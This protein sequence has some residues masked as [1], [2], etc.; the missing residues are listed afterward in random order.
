MRI[1]ILKRTL[2]AAVAS[3]VWMAG[4]SLPARAQDHQERKHEQKEMKKRE[5]QERKRQHAVAGNHGNHYGRISDERYRAHF[6]HKHQFRMVRFRRVEGYNRFAYS[7][8]TFGFVQPWP[9]GWFRND[10]VYVEYVDGGYY[11]CNPRQPGIRITLTI[12]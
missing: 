1:S 5:K 10:D 6:G 9:A 7:G 2:L 3:A 12:F 11:L 4:M 8:Y